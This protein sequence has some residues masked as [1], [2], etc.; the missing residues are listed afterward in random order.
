MRSLTEDRR[1]DGLGPNTDRSD[2]FGRLPRP[3]TPSAT[4]P[5]STTTSTRSCF[6][7]EDGCTEADADRFGSCISERIWVASPDG[8]GARELFPGTSDSRLALALS[9]DGRRLLYSVWDEGSV[10]RSFVVDLTGPNALRAEPGPVDGGEFDFSPDGAR[11]AFVRNVW[12]DP[13]DPYP[14]SVVAIL[15]LSTGEVT[16]LEATAIR[17]PD[18]HDRMPKWSPDGTRLLF[19]R[20][21][22]GPPTPEDRIEDS[23]LLVI[24]VDGSDLR[25]IVGAEQAPSSAEWAP[26]GTRIAIT[27]SPTTLK[28]DPLT[29]DRD[30]VLVLNEIYT[31]RPDGSDLRRLTDDTQLAADVPGPGSIGASLPTWTRSGEIAFIRTA[32]GD[33]GGGDMGV[34]PP[35]LWVVAADG[36][37]PR[38]VDLNDLEALSAAG[39][40]RC[41]YPPSTALA[42][43][44]AFWGQS[45]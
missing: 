26:D 20:D 11:L 32:W 6:V 1:R 39:C 41:P 3:R 43:R 37:D 36:S 12:T 8:T 28:D 40:L 44:P 17:S 13:N 35:G 31:V 19:I 34:L 21:E 9:P 4:R 27:S 29:G 25:L 22:I 7:G 42:P 33:Q 14:D 16:E 10:L 15:D 2:R 30:N 24:D 23:Q 5:S 38:E 45:R 18:G